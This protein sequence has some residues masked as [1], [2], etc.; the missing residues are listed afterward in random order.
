M[1]TCPNKSHPD[2]K[3]LVARHGEIG[4]MEMYIRNGYEIPSVPNKQHG[5]G[6]DIGGLTFKSRD[7]MQRLNDNPEL[8]KRI[9]DKLKQLYPNVNV[10]EGG[11]FNENGQ[12]K[13]LQPGEL[14]MHYRNAFYSA[15]AYSNDSLLETPP[16]EYAHEYIDMF[17]YHPLV[18]EGIK[19]YGEENLVTLMGK[20]FVSREVSGTFKKWSNRFWNM[21]R[22]LFGSPDIA[23]QLA[24]NFYQGKSL[25]SV[26]HQGTGIY[27][28][29]KMNEPYKRIDGAFNIDDKYYAK[30]INTPAEAISQESAYQGSKVELKEKASDG[31]NLNVYNAG[32]YFNDIIKILKNTHT[33]KKSDGTK[34]YANTAGLDKRLLND[35]EEVL[36]SEEDVKEITEAMLESET[37]QEVQERLT[38]NQYKA[39]EILMRAQQVL[40]YVGKLKSNYLDGNGKMVDKATVDEDIAQE[41]AYTQQKRKKLY[42][43]IPNEKLRKLVMKAEQVMRYQLNARL[44]AKYL[45][46]GENTLLSDIFYKGLDQA[47][48]NRAKITREVADRMKTLEKIEGYNK[49]SYHNNPYVDI[50][51]L[52][53]VK[54]R[55]IG[56]EVELTKAELLGLYLNL[57]QKDSRGTIMD[58]G[59]IIDKEIPGRDIPANTVYQLAVKAE[60]EINN[61]V[62]SD[63]AMMD[64]V[65]SIDS[66]LDYTYSVTNPVFKQENGY[67]LPKHDNYFP[68]FVGKKNTID[69]RRAHSTINDF[70]AGYARLGQDDP[71]RIGDAI[72]IM[73][74]VKHSSALYSS[75]AIPI[76][77]N[78]EILKKLS[79]IYKGQQE[80]IYIDAMNGALNRLESNASLYSNQGEKQYEKFINNLTSNFSVSVLG[81]N[82]GVMLKQP[83]SYLTAMEEI[84]KKYLKEA[85]WGIGGFVGI[86]PREII[87]S[88][89]WTGVKGGE[90][91]LPLEWKMDEKNPIYNEILERSPR[92][93]MRLEGMVSKEMGEALMN[94]EIGKDKIKMPWKENGESV[95]ISKARLME[96]IKMFDTATIMSLWKAVKLETAE[97]HPELQEGTPE[98]WDHVELR[99]TE[100]V[101]KTQPTYDLVNRSELGSMSNPIARMFAM[102]GSARSKVGMLMIDGVL[103]YMNNPTQE[104]KRKLINR[105]LNIMLTTSLTLAAI[106]MLKAG[107]LYGMDDDDIAEFTIHSMINN[108]MG[109]FYGLGNIASYVTSQLDDKPWHKTIQHPVEALGQDYA[110]AIAHLFKGNFTDGAIKGLEAVF[111]TTGLPLQAEVVP[112]A[113]YKTYIAED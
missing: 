56:G 11:L 20:E 29:Q 72:A 99:A 55:T 9:F 105:S 110:H 23:Y 22:S 24:D 80:E 3:T 108:N 27:R 48:T 103:S 54:V 65:K 106:D 42:D 33:I 87:K 100:I 85:G 77:N 91:K 53:T 88:L 39:V 81:M 35:T 5:N 62:E 15:I 13:E 31:L 92:L 63:K 83:V 26:K 19:R 112:K 97:M 8:G 6:F 94:S 111:K 44:F 70:R 104:N 50:N 75:F 93:A 109:Y 101:N 60:E 68:V 61:M 17:R 76:R 28:Y 82:V 89:T 49:W 73:D 51:E 102:F 18:Q 46:G 32:T 7:T 67:D 10:Y 90:T 84:N 30:T 40:N 71:L 38:E 47:E 95:Y 14:G 57:R 66:T 4:A 45:S 36:K 34:D 96:G 79:K 86:S 59:F 69:E 43:K 37:L 41:V 25:Q 98:Y 52:D 2:W 107:V 58:K 12:W 113:V 64:V 1:A 78:R 16:H 74:N 21:L